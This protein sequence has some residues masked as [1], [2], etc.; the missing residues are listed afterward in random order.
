MSTQSC[1]DLAM[2]LPSIFDG[3][4]HVN[5]E[6]AVLER[7]I[8]VLQELQVN[9]IFS[10]HQ[11]NLDRFEHELTEFR[12]GLIQ[13]RI[14]LAGVSTGDAVG[15]LRRVAE[16]EAQ[17]TALTVNTL[18]SA[19]NASAPPAGVL[20]PPI[21]TLQEVREV[22]ARNRT[23]TENMSIQSEVNAFLE[24]FALRA[25]EA[26]SKGEK[27][28]RAFQ[29]LEVWDDDDD[30]SRV[31]PVL[32][33][34]SSYDSCPKVKHLLPLDYAKYRALNDA[35]YNP[36]ITRFEGP[37]DRSTF[38]ACADFYVCVSLQKKSR[39]RFF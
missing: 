27:E 20:L 39:G 21:E 4:V 35:N 3:E 32:S 10:Q 24:D 19:G 1:A 28:V 30:K 37:I 25:K 33:N 7:Q 18:R 26:A 16:L 23:A 14:E 22:V 34:N 15:P 5:K 6:I 9:F 8:K 13:V 29:V 17:L 2:T 11:E 31:V 36:K 12:E 38:E